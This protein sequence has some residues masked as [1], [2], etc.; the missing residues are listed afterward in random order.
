MSRPS[1]EKRIED[2][3]VRIVEQ[4]EDVTDEGGSK[5]QSFD[6]TEFARSLV[7]YIF[8]AVIML[9]ALSTITLF[10]T[11]QTDFWTNLLQKIDTLS[12]M[13]SLMLSA[14]LEQMWNNKRK[15]RF[16]ITMLVEVAL[17][18]LGLMWYCA[19]SIADIIVSQKQADM[20]FTF[21]T[22]FQ[23]NQ[24]MLM[25]NKGYIIVGCIVIIFGF[26]LR[27]FKDID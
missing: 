2:E 13:F 25:F 24:N 18:A 9:V 26:G 3:A 7:T 5:K 21:E 14:A 8:T 19:R 1:D 6:W 11:G 4:G 17:A 23:D 10:D 20:V 22:F 15:L 16:K 12:L 27:A